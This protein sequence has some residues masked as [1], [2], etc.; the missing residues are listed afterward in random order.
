MRDNNIYALLKR[1]EI[2]IKDIAFVLQS[3]VVS[4]FKIIVAVILLFTLLGFLDYALSPVEYESKA[5]VLLESTGG[6][7]TS[8]ANALA[9]ILSGGTTGATSSGGSAVSPDM[10]RSIVSSQAFLN[11]LVVKKLPND[12]EGKDSITLMQYFALGNPTTFR[13]KILKLPSTLK[14]IFVKPEKFPS[15][16]IIPIARSV[17]TTKVVQDVISDDMFFSSKVPPIV[18]LDGMR[19]NVI[20]IM[21]LRVEVLISGK[22]ADV[23]VKMPDSFLAAAVNKLLL[24]QLI[25]YVTSYNTIK[26]RSNIAFLEKRFAETKAVYMSRQQ[27]LAG[28]RDNSFGVILQSAQTRQEVLANELTIAFNLYNQFAVQ[29]ESARIDLKKE[30]PLF[31]VLE[32]ISLPSQLVEPVLLKKLIRYLLISMFFIMIVIGYRILVPA[33]R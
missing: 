3:A 2:T 30:T 25:D 11:A 1:D 14:G 22:S 27:R 23:S 16:N 24:Q 33:K 13:Q 9:G 20:S 29:L 17:D 4:Q 8:T 21:K 18:Q 31:T 32:P 15:Q 26:Q 10:Y 19:S 7:S 6:S 28:V 5:S 12:P